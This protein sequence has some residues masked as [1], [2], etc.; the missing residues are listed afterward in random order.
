LIVVVSGPG[1]VGKG[2]L[3]R[4]VVAADDRLAL[5]RSWTTRA[6]RPGEAADAYVFVDQPTFTARVADGGFLEWAE[7][8]GDLYGTPMPEVGADGRLADGRDLLLEIDVQ[9]A[10]QVSRRHPDALFVL[11]VA[12]S[13]DAQ[14]QRL[15]GRGDPPE[16]VERRMAHAEA[17]VDAARALGAITV[18]NDVL[19]EAVAELEGV[20]DTARRDR[21][22]PAAG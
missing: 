15:E 17:E 14:R 13:A 12:P 20:I 8:L 3:V 21:T 5:S 10:A 7:F 2:T 18:V 19:A 1:G 22:D 9:G 11:I 6:P 4:E 16:Q